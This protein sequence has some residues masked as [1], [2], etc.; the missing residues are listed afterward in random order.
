[1]RRFAYA[2]DNKVISHMV[3]YYK[4]SQRHVQS[5]AGQKLQLRVIPSYKNNATLYAPINEPYR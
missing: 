2:E 5:K 1:M 4:P 3:G